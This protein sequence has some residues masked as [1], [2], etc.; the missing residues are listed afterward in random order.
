MR[1]S[2]LTTASD[3]PC[4]GIGGAFSQHVSGSFAGSGWAGV[5]LICLKL[6]ASGRKAQNSIKFVLSDLMKILSI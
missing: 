1:A 6:A 3:A 2:D 4:P 5:L